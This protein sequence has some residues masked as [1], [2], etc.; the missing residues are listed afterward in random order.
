MLTKIAH[1][2]LNIRDDHRIVYDKSK[3]NWKVKH[4]VH[5]DDVYYTEYNRNNEVIATYHV[6]HHM[7]SDTPNIVYKQGWVKYD[8][9][10][11]EVESSNDYPFYNH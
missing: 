4:G 5:M 2:V 8:L 1:K 11:A 10:N 6:F 7:S 3:S 9:S